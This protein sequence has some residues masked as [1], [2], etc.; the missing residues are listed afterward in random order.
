[1]VKF[2]KMRSS[3]QDEMY[4]TIVSTLALSHRQLFEAMMA[5]SSL[6]LA[7]VGG[8]SMS[9]A[10][11]RFD[12]SNQLLME[13]LEP[14]EHLDVTMLTIWFLL[15]YE[16][17]LAD[18]VAKCCNL[19]KYASDLLRQLLDTCDK[20]QAMDRLRYV[21]VRIVVS[22]SALDARAAFFGNAGHFLGTLRRCSYIYELIAKCPPS[23]VG[24]EPRN[25][26]QSPYQTSLCLAVRLRMIM[27]QIKLLNISKD[28]EEKRRGWDAV[29]AGLR[30]LRRE[31]DGRDCV[32]QA[33]FGVARGDAGAMPDVSAHQY[34]QMMLLA[35]FYGASILYQ[36]YRPTS[37]NFVTDEFLPAADCALRLIRLAERA[38]RA[39]PD[40]PQS[41]WPHLLIVAAMACQDPIYRSWVVQILK[42][43]ESWGTNLHKSRLLVEAIV[44][45]IQRTGKVDDLLSIMEQTTGLFVA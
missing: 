40:S 10:Q 36:E 9:K 45:R 17:L 22:M 42:G 25:L 15:N 44:D 32:T 24:G 1:M 23:H 33:V 41:V 2:S 29:D 3:D 16:C 26:P 13:D 28:A 34:N 35:T 20:Q 21:G 14:L 27:G 7:Q 19:L 12:L 31:L 39:R 8:K 11:E 43:A 30:M 37:R 18:G 4:T 6:H 5:W 38:N